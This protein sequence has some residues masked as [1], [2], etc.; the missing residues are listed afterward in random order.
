MLWTEGRS[1][2]PHEAAR[3]GECA[4]QSIRSKI[5]TRHVIDEPKAVKWLLTSPVAAWFWLVP[6]LWI[7]WK[8]VQAGEHKVVDP[9]WVR[10]G[11]ALQSYWQRVVSV[12]NP[13]QPAISF[14]WYRVLI[15]GLLDAKAYTWLAPLTAWGEVLVGIALVL[16]AFSGIAAFFGAFIHWD[17]MLASSAGSN[18]M[19]FVFTIGLM[20]AW[21]VAGYVGLDYFLLPWLGTPWSRKTVEPVPEPQGV[22]VRTFWATDPDEV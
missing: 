13:G 1:G 5:R 15:Q 12:P 2:L 17:L 19:L 21:R 10:T 6:R 3:R 9:E 22:A 14:D 7:G 16:G 18:P 8:W 20:L 4:L 11:V